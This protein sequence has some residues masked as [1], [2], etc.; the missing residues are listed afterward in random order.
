M[1]KRFAAIVEELDA[2]FHQLLEMRPSKPLALPRE[3]PQAGIYLL[4]EDEKYLYVGRSN[5]IRKRISNHCRASAT[6]KMA[7]FAFRLARESTGQMKATYKPEGSR[8][9]LMKSPTF[10]A[11]FETAKGRIRDMDVRFVA[12]AEPVRQ[13]VLEIYVAVVLGTPYND[14]D[15]H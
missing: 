3:A 2:S 11:A 10:V 4:S 15:T 8:G 13:A 7:A 12:E 9:D 14:F 6:Y 1:D 5:R